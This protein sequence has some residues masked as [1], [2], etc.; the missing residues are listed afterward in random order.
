MPR[1][2]TYHHRITVRIT[3]DEYSRLT[4]LAKELDLGLSHT[5]RTLISPPPNPF[6]SLLSDYIANQGEVQDEK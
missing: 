6:R 5:I 1:P 2:L 4:R 3:D